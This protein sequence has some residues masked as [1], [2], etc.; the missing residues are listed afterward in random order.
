MSLPGVHHSKG[1]GRLLTGASTSRTWTGSTLVE[2]AK[3]STGV[4]RKFEKCSTFGES[5]SRIDAECWPY[6]H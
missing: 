4:P 3:I 1:V 5:E 6:L 2:I